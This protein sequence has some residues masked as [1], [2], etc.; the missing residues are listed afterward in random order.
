MSFDEEEFQ[1]VYIWDG[2]FPPAIYEGTGDVLIENIPI[3][4]ISMIESQ[5]HRVLFHLARRWLSQTDG[6]PIL[7][8]NL[9]KHQLIVE[10]GNHRIF[11][12]WLDGYNTFDGIVYGSDW[13][14]QLRS[15]FDDEERFNWGKE[16]I[17]YKNHPLMINPN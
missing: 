10:D 4:E 2:D 3:K 13:H 14:S 12:R 17:E 5:G 8:Y 1:D 11:Q 7:W 6:Y 16:K 9:D 15:V